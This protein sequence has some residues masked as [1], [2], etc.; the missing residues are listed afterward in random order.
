MDGAD[1][2][3][4]SRVGFVE[5]S[6]ALSLA[7]GRTAARGFEGEWPAFAVIEVDQRL[8]ERASALAV[9]R[10]LRSLDAL[11]LASALLLPRD[12]VVVATWDRRLHAAGLAESVE[13]L[14]RSLD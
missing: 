13:L 10:G 8:V 1:E 14:P 12:G 3:F 2:W 11:H 7:G 5:V 4:V 6:R 9:K